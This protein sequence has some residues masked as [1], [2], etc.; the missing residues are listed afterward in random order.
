MHCGKDTT[1]NTMSNAHA[2][3]KLAWDQVLQCGKKA[4]NGYVADFFFA[5]ADFFSFFPQHRA[6]SQEE[7]CKQIQ[8]CCVVQYTLA[9]MEKKK[10]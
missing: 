4:K 3:P 1:L 6:W 2:W 8:H 9:I 10:C 5:N 7:L